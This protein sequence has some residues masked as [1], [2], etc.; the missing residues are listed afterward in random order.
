MGPRVLTAGPLIDAPPSS[1]QRDPDWAYVETEAQIRAEVR[2]ERASGVDVVKLYCGLEPTLVAAAIDE[3]HRLG[4]PVIGHM[5]ATSWLQA[6]R[7]GIDTLVHSFIAMIP[8]LPRNAM[9]DV[10]DGGYLNWTNRDGEYYRRWRERFHLD[11]AEMEALIS[12]LLDNDVEINPTLVLYEAMLWGD[13]RNYLQRM[14]PWLAPERDVPGWWGD[15][16]QRYPDTAEWSAQD[17]SEAKAT[18]PTILS[19]FRML[20]ERGVLITAGSDM[21]NAWMTPGVSFHRELELL[22]QAG[23]SPLD[24]LKIATMNGAEALRIIDDVGTIEPRKRGDL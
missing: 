9:Q 16:R 20:H 5:C 10:V 23:I 2:R 22:V 3:S 13:D 4:L 21:G 15:W 14:E 17:F 1:G 12:A 24:V 19:F 18:F 6:A 8:P 11:G 7:A